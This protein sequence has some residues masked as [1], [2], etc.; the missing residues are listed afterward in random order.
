V[1][2]R[3][4]G[5]DLFVDRPRAMT[6]KFSGDLA[7][8]QAM[9]PI[10]PSTRAVAARNAPSASLTAGVTAIS[11]NPSIFIASQLTAVLTP[12]QPEGLAD[13]KSPQEPKRPLLSNLHRYQ[14][15]GG[16]VRPQA[17]LQ[18]LLMGRAPLLQWTSRV[19]RARSWLGA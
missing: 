12:H 8:P 7:H 1:Q 19:T 18:T 14:P 6:G 5:D 2:D 3:R 17:S 4:D 10:G 9:A 15:R 13:H 16:T 11:A